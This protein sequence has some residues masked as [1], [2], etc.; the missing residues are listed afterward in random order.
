MIGKLI[1][2]FLFSG[3]AIYLT[4]QNT[5]LSLFIQACSDVGLIFWL[6]VGG[7]FLLQQLLRAFR[8]QRIIQ[9]QVS[10]YSLFESHTLLCISFL[11]INTFPI[12]LGE[13]ARPIL[14]ENQRN[15][16]FGS[17][18]ALV[19]LERM[20]DLLAAMVMILLAI[21][22]AS[23]SF[24][25]DFTWFEQLQ[26]LSQIGVWIL[27]IV[28]LGSIAFAKSIRQFAPAFLHQFLDFLSQISTL[29]LLEIILSTIIIW[30]MSCG[31]YICAAIGFSVDGIGFFE[32]MGILSSTMLGMAPPSAPG[33]AGTYEA[34]FMVA[35][36]S[37]ATIEK[38]KALAMAIS[39]HVWVNL[40]QACTAICSLPYIGISL[41]DLTKRIFAQL[42]SKSKT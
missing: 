12:R 23:F 38:E 36:Y 33:F 34:A 30:T 35:L 5:D 17:G 11:C 14:L 27:G 40:V 26:S 8:Q 20:L 18:I 19:F 21:S 15:I 6:G 4:L 10:D 41:K 1:I 13:F 32:A 29:R 42:R 39:F 37:F 2:G 3:I 16:S 7:I 31:M 9:T 22:Y 28:I 24:G 25:H